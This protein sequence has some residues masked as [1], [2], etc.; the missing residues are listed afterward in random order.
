[1]ASTFSFFNTATLIPSK[2]KNLR[3]AASM[4]S[5]HNL[6]TQRKKS[7]LNA[8]LS[9][10]SDA[11]LKE[12]DLRRRA[13]FIESL[14]IVTFRHENFLKIRSRHDEIEILWLADA[15]LSVRNIGYTQR[16]HQPCRPAGQRCRRYLR[17]IIEAGEDADCNTLKTVLAE[18]VFHGGFGAATIRRLAHGYAEMLPR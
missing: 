16:L 2:K 9:T 14:A 12:K 1:V 11:W 4:S 5:W 13:K 3:A 8:R 17:E 7:A 15:W 10:D 6:A 18:I